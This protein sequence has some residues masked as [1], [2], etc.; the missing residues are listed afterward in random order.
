LLDRVLAT[1]RDPQ[2]APTLLRD[3]CNIQTVVT[4]LGNRSADPARS[5]DNV[6]YTL[7]VH[8]LFCPG[9][10]TD[11]APFFTGRTTKGEYYEALS[12]LFGE[13]PSTLE[14]LGQLLRDW[15]DRTV[16][17]RVRFSNTFLPID[18]R[19]VPPDESQAQFVLAQAAG[20]CDLSGSDID[21]LIRFLTWEFLGWHH[22]N[23]KAFQIAVGA[24]YVGADGRSVPRFQESW[25]TEMAQTFH[26]FGNV[27]F[28][29]L[30]ASDMLSQEVASLMQQF[31]NVYASGY[32]L[33]NFVP[34]TVERIF[35]LRV[36]MAPMTKIGGFLSDASYA[37]W[38]YGRLQVA[39]KAIAVS[40]ARLVEAGYYEEHD[41]PPILQQV[42]HDT[43][44]DLC[45]LSPR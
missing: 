23:H 17:G 20:G 3:R 27:R 8:D 32:W 28:D 40:L 16:T 37:E 22:D 44:R 43:P 19:L 14:Q 35:S 39:K 9:V 38:T 5:P 34:A 6:L 18:Q 26:H 33:H 15:L 2:W 12:A 29:L 21:A 30:I 7:D 36:Q 11:L 1:G 4:S 13:R 41:I 45:D 10:A 42:L 25:T 24:E 31:P